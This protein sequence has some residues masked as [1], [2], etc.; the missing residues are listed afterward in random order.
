MQDLKGK[1]ALVTGGGRGIG[2][3]IARRLVA[4]GAAVA[5]TYSRSAEQ[6]RQFVAETEEAGGRGLAVKADNRDAQAVEAAVEQ[7]VSSFGGIDIL[8]NNAGIFEAR[9]LAEFSDEDF[10]RTMDVN[11]K[12]V[13]VATRSAAKHMRD[14]GR[15]I[16]I[17]S[18]LAERVPAPGISLYAMSKA[19]LIGF[20]KGAARDLG[21]RGITVNLVQPGSTNTEMNPADGETADMQRSYM[22]IPRY[23]DA[24]E[25]AGLVAWLAGPDGRGVTG[26]S[27]TIDG[28]ANA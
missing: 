24:A 17:G 7:T 12:A 27:F 2:L 11:V 20:T 25:V 22:A 28:G 8:V 15:I 1:V 6:A 16:S 13:F 21:P 9:P 23:N 5:V 4:Q 26:A 10:N 3:A 19:A 14:G 18:N